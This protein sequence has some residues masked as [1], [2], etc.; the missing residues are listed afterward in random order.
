MY[1]DLTK[2]TVPY[3][4]GSESLIKRKNWEVIVDEATGKKWSSFHDSK[5]GMV[6]PTC[7]LFNI[8][9]SKG[10]PVKTVRLDPAGE[11]HKLEK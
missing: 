9:K 3:A 2:V 4:D 1:L 7:E 10:I 8:L 5:N 6:E 11:N